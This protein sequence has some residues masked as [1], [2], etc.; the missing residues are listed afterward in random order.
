MSSMRSTS[1][2]TSCR[3]AGGTT[4]HD[5]A[6]PSSRATVNPIARSSV[7]TVSAGT[8]A[9]STRAMRAA[10]S[11]SGAGAARCAADVEHGG[12]GPASDG[13]EQRS[14]LR[15]PLQRRGRIDA[16]LEPVARVARHAGA[17]A[18]DPHAAR[19][20]QRDLQQHVDRALR[21]LRV[22]SAHDARDGLRAL[23]IGDDERLAVERARL[24]VER[25]QRLARR[26]RGAR[27][28]SSPPAWTRS[29]ACIGC[30]SPCST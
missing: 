3:H 24:A 7:S 8:A 20:E 30:P 23:R 4:V 15:E 25:R 18:R 29:N 9:P 13:D 6:S 12:H 16:A 22:A 26:G 11:D 28:S 2:V 17:P 10:R 21:D 19:L 5:A 14:R 27:R 1:R